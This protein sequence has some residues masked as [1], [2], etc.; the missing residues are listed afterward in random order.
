[1]R[2]P[3]PSNILYNF[4]TINVNVL[5]CFQSFFLSNFYV[6]SLNDLHEM[7]TQLGRILTYELIIIKEC[8]GCLVQPCFCPSATELGLRRQD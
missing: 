3:R 2:L 4:I 7:P 1:M 8:A 5:M 6:K